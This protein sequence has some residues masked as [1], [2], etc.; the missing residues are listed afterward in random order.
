MKK[1][2]EEDK[3]DPKDLFYDRANYLTFVEN[4][5]EINLDAFLEIIFLFDSVIEFPFEE[6]LCKE[7]IRWRDCPEDPYE[8]GQPFIYNA[9]TLSIDEVEQKDGS[10]AKRPRQRLILKDNDEA[11]N[12]VR[13]SQ[14]SIMS[15]ISYIGKSRKSENARF[16]FA[17]AIDLDGVGMPQIRDLFYQAKNKLVP[18][19]NLIVNSGY[20][21]HLYYLLKKP[22][23]LYDNYKKVLSKLKHGLTA[24]IWNSYTSTIEKK[25]FQGIFQG[26]RVPESL[27]KFGVPVQAFYNSDV[28]KYDIEGLREFSKYSITKEEAIMIDKNQ[29][30][31]TRFSLSEAQEKYPEWYQ[32]VIIEKN[33]TPRRKWKLNRKLYD[34]WLRRL[35]ENKGKEVKE[36]HRYFCLLS[37]VVFAVKCGVSYEE[38]REDCFRLIPILDEITENSNNHFTAEDVEDVLLAYKDEYCTFPRKTIESLTGLSI[39]TCRRKGRSQEL[40]LKGARALLEIYNPN[41]REGNGRPKGTIKTAE[42][43]PK[44]QL[45]LEWRNKNKKGNKSQCSRE[46]GLSR[47]TVIK[48]WDKV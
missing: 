34:W 36:G 8:E 2:K 39:E 29:S 26:F 20:G 48:W 37:L 18:K 22:I 46:T 3:R 31:P 27:T 6:Q 47:P 44:A 45:V 21:V 17:F 9:I 25:Q 19:P 7:Y 23:P 15:P 1:K 33:K 11:L 24:E 28:K 40:H 14:F 35:F 16:L 5:E 30:K 12:F 41:W 4:Y 43:S 42:N 32:K 13:G 10:F 38:V